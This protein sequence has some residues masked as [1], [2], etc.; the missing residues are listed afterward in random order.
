MKQRLNIVIRYIVFWF[1][2]FELS[3][4]FFLLYNISFTKELSFGVIIHTFTSGF[5]HDASMLGYI[6][7]LTSLGLILSLFVKNNRVT[8][9]LFKTIT[10]VLL[11]PFSLVTVADA[12]LYR[13]WGY[14]MDCSALQYL[15]LP[16]E[17]LS[18]IPLWHLLILLVAVGVIV[19]A[20]YVLYKKYVAVLFQRILPASKWFCGI[21]LII[22][23]LSIIPI[24][25]GLSVAA[26]R[27][28]TV[29]FCSE[30]FANHAA[31]NDHWHFL[32][33][34][35]YS[36]NEVADVF[37]DEA[38]CDAICNSLLQNNSASP[39][40]LITSKRPNIILFILESFTA[41]QIEVL[42]GKT[43]ITPQLDSIAHSGV[44]FS[45]CYSNGS[46]S[47]MGIV[48]ILSGYPA[49]PTTAII[50]YTEKMEKL[51]YLSKVFDSLGY[52][53]SFFHGGDIRF[54]NMNSYFRNG[55]FEKCVTINDFSEKDCNSKWGAFDHVVCNRLFKDLHTEQSP[56]FAVCYTLS[57]HEPFEVPMKS[58][59]YAEDEYSK[60]LNSVHYADS[61]LGDFMRKAKQESWWNNTLVIFV[62]DH[63]ARMP[64]TILSSDPK[65]YH[66]PMIWAGGVVEK[67][68]VIADLVNQ[69]DLPMMLC[70]QLGIPSARFTFSK[71][72]LSGDKPFAYYSYN[73]GCGYLRDNQFFVWDNESS[74]IIDKSENIADTTILQGKAF[75]QKIT[76]DFCRK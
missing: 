69:C 28:G 4:C 16:K 54:G 74:S 45:N 68:T 37:M 67:D 32:N 41:S 60:F 53:L 46:K 40:Q 59:F 42:G 19:F 9:I 44:L 18:S 10:L 34:F 55:G 22:I 71:D 36:K 7:S 14:R 11:V 6:A 38:E 29:Y 72:V 26:L 35:V 58:K 65:K 70:N 33:S 62:S 24:R 39:V 56:F 1:L 12:E 48:S 21:F 43:G 49:Q 23:G 5:Q 8:E 31:I 76:T 2:F 3:R 66:I 25:G 50:K 27:T 20:F 57:S 61:C 75:L 64:H 63:G 13:N 52:N 15:A 51:P 17:A 73:N 47:E 30:P